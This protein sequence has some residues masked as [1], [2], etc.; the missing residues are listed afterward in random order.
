MAKD[1]GCKD[2]CACSKPKL[3]EYVP[4]P[5]QVVLVAKKESS[6]R[7]LLK[8]LTWNLTDWSA[9]VVIAFLFTKDVKTALAIGVVQQL[10][11]ASLYFFHERVWARVKRV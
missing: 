3:G 11:E 2:G 1:E 4:V 8:T 5:Q 9:T 10:W 6:L 7:S